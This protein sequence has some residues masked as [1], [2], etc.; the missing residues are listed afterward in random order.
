[1]KKRKKIWIP[2][3][4]V[5]LVAAVGGGLALYFTQR[6]KAA[7]GVYDIN[8]LSVM[9][10]W[11]D[12]KTSSGSVST[13][14][15]QTVYLS[16]TQEVTE[17]HVQEGQ[18]V[19]KGTTLL[20]YDTTLSQLSL[21]RKDL[22]IQRAK[23]RL[24]DAQD[25]L[26]EIKKMKPISYSTTTRPTTKPTTRPTTKPAS[27]VPSE[28][29]GERRFL[30]LGGAG[31]A[32]D[33]KVL[34][35]RQSQTFDDALIAE[36]LDGAESLYT[37]LEVRQNDRAAGTL[38]SRTG[39]YFQAVQETVGA[40]SATTTAAEGGSYGVHL[41]SEVTTAPSDAP[42]DE[43]SSEPSTDPSE[44]PTQPPT[45]EP[46]EPDPPP[47]TEPVPPTTPS[48]PALVTRYVFTF[49]Q[50]SQKQEDDE[51]DDAGSDISS[52]SG[53]SVDMNSGYTANEIAQMRSDKEAEIKDLQFSI[54]MAEAEYKI[55]KK[56]FDNGEVKSEVDGY[57]VSVQTPE[58]ALANNEPV[59]KVSGGGG[60]FIQG[61]VGE[62]NRNEIEIGQTV[63][64]MSYNTGESF[65][66]TITAVG[67][68]PLTGTWYSGDGNA[69]VSY[70]PFTVTIDE[71][72][73]LEAGTYTQITY[74]SA[75]A[76]EDGFY[77]DSAFI[78]TE[79]GKSYVYVQNDEGLLEKREV[80]TGPTLWG[81]YIKVY[82]GVSTDSYI[83]FPYGVEEG[84]PTELKDL[85]DLYNY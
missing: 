47:T 54:K 75:N 36:I 49:F 46:T 69:T 38:L 65:E 15:L 26:A 16:A 4:S 35:V 27:Q 14:Q 72:A 77:L 64:V 34:W 31:T 68:Y 50:V 48:E 41:L 52:G 58:E 81:S 59:V 63:Q 20:T 8:Q 42:T 84:A 24:E 60:F 53:S 1:M 7:V 28:E 12:E 43:P 55:M 3:V 37:I 25:Q 30:D 13:D 6:P 82:S 22:E 62:L 79:A 83:A 33:P 32:G 56:E 45:E 85:S 18:K 21:D 19:T 2:I 73:N 39:V 71:S 17:I 5:L 23:L 66:G 80:Q 76:E 78:R 29:L 9:N 40:A 44:E 51:D 10:Y 67:D 57:V 74:S 11:G 61:S 70:Y